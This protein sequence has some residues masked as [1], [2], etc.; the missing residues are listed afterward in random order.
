MVQDDVYLDES[1]EFPALVAPTPVVVPHGRAAPEGGRATYRR[2]CLIRTC[3]HGGGSGFTRAE[4]HGYSG[5]GAMLT[6][7]ATSAGVN[8]SEGTASPGA[9]VESSPS[10][11]ERDEA[12]DSPSPE[13]GRRAAYEL[14]SP[15]VRQGR[16]CEE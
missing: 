3:H 11:F 16:T 7:S 10:A 14:A 2:V 9:S 5:E 4:Q 8:K 1:S 15:V 13:P 6:L 12:D